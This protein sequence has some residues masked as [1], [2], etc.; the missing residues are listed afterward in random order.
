MDHLTPGYRETRLRRRHEAHT[1]RVLVWAL[2]GALA[3]LT[4]V[5]AAHTAPDALLIAGTIAALLYGAT[6]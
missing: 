1:A 5:W 4:L 6:R 2:L 3:S